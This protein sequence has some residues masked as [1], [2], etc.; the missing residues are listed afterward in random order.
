ML[1]LV[2][3]CGMLNLSGSLNNGWFSAKDWRRYISTP[4]RERRIPTADQANRRK[5]PDG[6][7]LAYILGNNDPV[8]GLYGPGMERRIRYI[9]LAGIGFLL[10][11]PD[12]RSLVLQ[13][14]CHYFY[15]PR[16]RAGARERSLLEGQVARG[17][18]VDLGNDLYKVSH[19]N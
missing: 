1:L 10:D 12:F 19:A 7:P 14:G 11:H 15:F 2:M 4:W 3:L 5:I 8:Y 6:E 18:F 16:N 9:R 17:D 13:A